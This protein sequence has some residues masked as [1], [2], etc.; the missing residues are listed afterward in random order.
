MWLELT[1]TQWFILNQ[2]FW[3][4]DDHVL[5][6]VHS[7]AVLCWYENKLMT[8][9]SCLLSLF[10]VNYK[11]GNC[12]VWYICHEEMSR[13]LFIPQFYSLEW[14]CTCTVPEPERLQLIVWCR[15]SS[16]LTC[17]SSTKRRKT[18]QDAASRWLS[19]CR[20]QRG[21]WA[22]ASPSSASTP[23]TMAPP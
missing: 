16:A 21:R 7:K 18:V 4:H 17:C 19:L 3:G 10:C 13:C 9:L 22:M 11:A 6:E 15:A 5:T 2:F 14:L 1:W 12:P 23:P 20:P 8:R